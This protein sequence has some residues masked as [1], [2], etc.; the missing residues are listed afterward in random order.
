MT[1]RRYGVPD[2]E[3]PEWTAER[4]ARARPAREVLPPALFA[5]LT[6]GKPEGS[7]AEP[8]TVPV[9]LRLDREVVEA[10]RATGA[11]WETRIAA[12]LRRAAKRLRATEH[13]SAS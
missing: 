4:L 12:V 10:F 3:N 11:G 5:A 8:P 1:K 7:E 2:E 9:T 13:S 6:K